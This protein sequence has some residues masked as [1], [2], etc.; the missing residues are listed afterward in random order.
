MGLQPNGK[1]RFPGVEEAEEDGGDVFG[2]AGGAVGR[3]DGG[4]VDV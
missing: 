3:F 2:G 1:I 4:L